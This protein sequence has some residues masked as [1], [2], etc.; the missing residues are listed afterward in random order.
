MKNSFK[1]SLL[2]FCVLLGITFITSYFY[3]GAITLLAF[4]NTSFTFSSILL[5]LSLLTLVTK[6]GF[7]DGITYSFRR[8]FASSQPDK[9]LEDDIRNEMRPPSELLQPLS[10][11]PMLLASLLLF[12][13]MLVSLFV[14]YNS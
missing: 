2:F 7:F 5:F 8:I 3:Y 9:Q 6:R 14:F 4:I 1:G 11:K 10:T 12:L 13:S